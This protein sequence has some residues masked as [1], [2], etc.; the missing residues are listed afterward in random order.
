MTGFIK[1]FDHFMVHIPPV[2]FTLKFSPGG[3]A[4][5]VTRMIFSTFT[6]CSCNDEIA[7]DTVLPVSVCRN[8]IVINPQ[9]K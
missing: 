8:T 7:L 1:L 5:N 6:P 9:V 3:V 4:N 2:D